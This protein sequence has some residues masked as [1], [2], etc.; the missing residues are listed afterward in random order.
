MGE[1]LRL[2]KDFHYQANKDLTDKEFKIYLAMMRRLFFEKRKPING[3]EIV[4]YSWS[5]AK[6]DGIK[7]SKSKFYLAMASLTQK[8]YVIIFKKGSFGGKHKETQY[9]LKKH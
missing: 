3:S 1:H 4:K 8:N 2:Y 5:L 6:L 7:V 9:R